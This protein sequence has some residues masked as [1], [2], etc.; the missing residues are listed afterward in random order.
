MNILVNGQQTTVNSLCP[1]FNSYFKFAN[2]E[3]QATHNYA[4]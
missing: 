3:L 1:N 2:N 4:L